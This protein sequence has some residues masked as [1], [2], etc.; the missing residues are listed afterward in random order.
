MFIADLDLCRYHPGPLDAENWTSPLLAVGWLEHPHGFTSG[1]TEKALVEKLYAMLE[2]I[3]SAY[4]HY[5]FR[6]VVDCS[7]CLASGHPF[8]IPRYSQT[9][10]FVP[11]HDVVYVAPG[12]IVHYIEAHAYLPPEQ[13]VDAVLR[14]PDCLSDEYCAALVRSNRGK[15]LPIESADAHAD[16]FRRRLSKFLRK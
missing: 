11:G 4:F 7:L 6:G 5:Q 13:F 8:P 9:N 12:G 1:V 3:Q 14:C 15:E 10:I 16:S 2:K